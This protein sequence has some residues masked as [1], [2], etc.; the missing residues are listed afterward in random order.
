[1]KINELIETKTNGI[2][3]KPLYLKNENGENIEV[4]S[5]TIMCG[6]FNSEN[7]KYVMDNIIR[8]YTGSKEYNDFVEI[9]LDNPYVRVIIEG[10][11][12]LD[13]EEFINQNL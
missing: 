11:N 13:Y 4:G 10:I 6:G 9:F 2:F 5:V 12:E 8:E 1:M 7:P 3:K